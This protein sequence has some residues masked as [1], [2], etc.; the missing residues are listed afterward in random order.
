M[1]LTTKEVVS[2]Y[3]VLKEAKLTKME[4]SDKMSVLKIMRVLKPISEEWESFMQTIDDKVKGENH[5][6]IIEKAREWERDKEKTTLSENEKREINEYLFKF[7]KDKNTCIGDELNK[8][9]E[10][11]ITKISSSAYEK[12]VESNDFEVDKLLTCE[13]IVNS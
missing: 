3:N 2:V 1:K 11:D 7:N 5:D 13:I 10:L 12:L 6:E 9:L 8:E 4:I